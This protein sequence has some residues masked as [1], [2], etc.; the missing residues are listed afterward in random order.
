MLEN[1][2]SKEFHDANTLL[3]NTNTFLLDISLPLISYLLTKNDDFEEF[4][5]RACWGNRRFA[6]GSLTPDLLEKTN[7]FLSFMTRCGGCSCH[8]EKN[9]TELYQEVV[10]PLHEYC[11]LL[12]QI[13]DK[14]DFN[15]KLAI[16]SSDD[17]GEDYNT[18]K[19]SLTGRH[20]DLAQAEKA[21]LCWQG[22]VP[23]HLMQ[24]SILQL[25]YGYIKKLI[26]AC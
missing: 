1:S 15:E 21:V 5:R 7:D 22:A 6:S 11:T 16:A 23:D 17:F 3:N 14:S 24:E 12:L 9:W 20:I 26:N 4:L 19:N 2:F 10:E 18:I 25:R 8:E 13:V